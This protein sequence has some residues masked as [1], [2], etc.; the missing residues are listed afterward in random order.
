M[1]LGEASYL[2]RHNAF[3]AQQRDRL[4]Q[5]DHVALQTG[6]P[7]LSGSDSSTF[8]IGQPGLEV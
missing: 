1:C 6:D 4:A 3:T 5:L 2:L 8:L 7:Y